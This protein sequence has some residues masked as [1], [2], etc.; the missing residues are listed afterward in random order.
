MSMD[1]AHTDE[2]RGRIKKIFLNSLLMALGLSAV[3]AV[4]LFWWFRGQSDTPY[5]L[6]LLFSQTIVIYFLTICGF[7]FGS[8]PQRRRYLAR[9][10]AEQYGGHFPDAAFEYRSRASL[11]GL[12]LVHVRIGDR[13]DV[14]RGPVKAWIAI[15]S[16]HAIGVIFASGGLAIAP[17]SFGG[18]AIGLVPFGAIALGV[19]PLGAIS[20]RRLGVWRSGHRLAGSLR[21]RRRME[22]RAGRNGGRARFCARRHRS[23]RAGQHRN[24]PAIFP[25]TSLFPNRAGDRQSRLLADA[26]VG[27]SGFVASARRRAG[28]PPPGTRQPLT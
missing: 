24:R 17:I 26:V 1:E 6:E 9:I 15:G 3:S 8:L 4:P 27:D 13:F 18:I 7:V 2:E 16:S 22:C 23:C 5:V 20:R 12:P 14:V 19:F 10:L 28:T 21:L 25:G 11:F